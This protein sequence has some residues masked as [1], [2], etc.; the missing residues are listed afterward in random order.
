MKI[1]PESDPMGC[2]IVDYFEQRCEKS[3]L[4][5][6]SSLFEDDVMPVANLFRT[7]SQMPELERRALSL[8]SGRVL[9]VGAGAGC[10]SLALQQRGLRVTAIDISELSVE[11]MR[12]RGVEDVRCADFFADELTEHFHTV[13]LLMNGLGIAGE[14]S[15]L[16]DL[17]LRAKSLLEPGGCILADSSDLRYVFEDE[18]GYFEYDSESD[19][20][21]GEVDFSMHYKGIDGRPFNWLYVDFATLSE[22]AARCGLKAECVQEGTHYD[23]LARLK[24]VD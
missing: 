11:T 12:R 2:A 18:D 14:L 22:V 6:R 4:V 16:P 21:Y 5:V 3:P 20:Y 9:D 8:C 13:L 1:Y 10:H 17:L 15:R 24:S 19:P 23:Y 7:E